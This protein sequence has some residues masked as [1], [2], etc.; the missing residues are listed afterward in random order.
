MELDTKN[1]RATSILLV[2]VSKQDSI[3]EYS[4]E[5]FKVST[6]DHLVKLHR[7]GDKT[8][9]FCHSDCS[10]KIHTTSSVNTLIQ[11]PSRT[12]DLNGCGRRCGH[13]HPA[14]QSQSTSSI[15]AC[16]ITIHVYPLICDS[17]LFSLAAGSVGPWLVVYI[18]QHCGYRSLQDPGSKT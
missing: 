11:S 4:T 13:S 10:D 12:Q 5:D 3:L 2:F 17:S 7:V 18:G 9:V 15:L 6:V 16:E 8:S 1:L 14:Q